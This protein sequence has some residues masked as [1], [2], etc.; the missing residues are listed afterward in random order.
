MGELDLVTLRDGDSVVA[1]APERGGIATRFDVGDRRVLFM[2]QETLRDPTKN[3]RGGVPVLFPT[4][5]KLADDKWSYAGKNGS[6]KQHGF[7]RNLAW[8]VGER[9]AGTAVLSLESSDATRA[10]FPWDFAFDMTFTVKGPTLRLEQRVTNTGAGTMPFGVG[11]HP[12][13][14]VADA[15]KP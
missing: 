5:G 3:V 15:D 11:F 2:D 6:M 4:P 8:R 14:V 9:G 13:F 1:I 7:A 12:Y 10:Q